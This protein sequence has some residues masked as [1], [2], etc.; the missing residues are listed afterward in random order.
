MVSKGQIVDHLLRKKWIQSSIIV[1][2][3]HSHKVEIWSCWTQVCGVF[4][5]SKIENSTKLNSG[6]G[7]L[8]HNGS[9]GC[10]DDD[11][12]DGD[13]GDDILPAKS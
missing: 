5:W 4:V 3:L 7:N 8:D 2:E 1:K 10:N 13:D 6:P 9:T 12:G 11:D